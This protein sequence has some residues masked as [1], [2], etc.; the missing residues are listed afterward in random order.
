MKTTSA[1]KYQTQAKTLLP[2]KFISPHTPPAF[3]T[4]PSNEEA[5]TQICAWPTWPKQALIIQGAVGCGKTYIGQL[6]QRNVTAFQWPQDA[7]I[8]N[9]FEQKKAP[10]LL[11]DNLEIHFSSE[12]RTRQLLGALN[13][14]REKGGTCLLL[15]NTPFALPKLRDLS[16]RLKAIVTISLKAPDDKLFERVLQSLFEKKQR[17]VPYD[18]ISFLS[19]RIPRKMHVAQN[20][21]TLLNKESLEQKKKL[22]R[23]FVKAFIR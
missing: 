20:I 14:V 11:V 8:F 18:V 22:T 9:L 12:M 17:F 6:W 16:S 5:W 3:H 21:V 13:T 7:T 2:L 10:H 23:D 15:A 1:D 19:L 4:S